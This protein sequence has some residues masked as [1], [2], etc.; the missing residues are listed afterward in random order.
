MSPCL[1]FRR[2]ALSHIFGVYSSNG[3]IPSSSILEAKHIVKGRQQSVY[4]PI[5]WLGFLTLNLGL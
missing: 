3:V 5:P 1:R 4:M 2:L